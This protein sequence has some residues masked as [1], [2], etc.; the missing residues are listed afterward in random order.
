MK[1]VKVENPEG[2]LKQVN[3]QLPQWLI[4]DLK[5]YARLHSWS[6]T[7]TVRSFLHSA[8]FSAKKHCICCKHTPGYGPGRVPCLFHGPDLGRMMADGE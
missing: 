4:D 3:F 7:V 6:L 1:R 8:I 5:E 2:Q